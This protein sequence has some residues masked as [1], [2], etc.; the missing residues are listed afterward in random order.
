M[1]FG[2]L[3][4]SNTSNN[5]PSNVRDSE[6]AICLDPF[7]DFTADGIH[8]AFTLGRHPDGRCGH[9]FHASCLLKHLA[10]DVTVQSCPSCR[11]PVHPGLRF[12]LL[13]T[14]PRSVVG[15][16]AAFLKEQ[17][18]DGADPN[19]RSAGLTPLQ[20]AVGVRFVE[21]ISLLLAAGANVNAPLDEHVPRFLK[22]SGALYLAAF[23]G[24][25]E[26]VELLLDTGASL[27]ESEWLAPNSRLDADSSS[28]VASLLHDDKTIFKLLLERCPMCRPHVDAAFEYACDHNLIGV[29]MALSERALPPKIDRVLMLERAVTNGFAD[30]VQLLVNAFDVD[31][32]DDFAM[33]PAFVASVVTQ[34][35]L[36]ATVFLESA[37]DWIP[38]AWHFFG[39]HD[40][41]IG[42]YSRPTR[43]LR[44][45]SLRFGETEGLLFLKGVCDLNN[46]V[47]GFNRYTCPSSAPARYNDH[48]H[49]LM[50]DLRVSEML[51]IVLGDS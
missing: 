25:V 29:V 31:D 20:H 38:V 13:P 24:W 37:W 32:M 17:L 8:R 34:R 15:R 48:F 22:S 30:V 7:S 9:T 46:E 43:Q 5:V 39:A 35:T 23:S 42:Q 36:C 12:M 21:G 1:Q 45:R 18:D 4:L 6:C 3:L 33:A 41:S 49:Y 26:G 40:R 44:T 19:V 51:R 16:N 27:E 50:L 14:L 28:L 11:T 10:S 47:A 2:S